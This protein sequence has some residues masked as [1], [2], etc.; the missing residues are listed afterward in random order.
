MVGF[1]RV[2]G[3]DHYVAG[4]VY[5][6]QQ[7]KAFKIAVKT[8]TDAVDLRVTDGKYVEC[9]LEKIIRELNPAMYFTPADASGVICVVL[10]GHAVSAESLQIRIRNV[11]KGAALLPDGSQDMNFGQGT[12]VTQATSLIAG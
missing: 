12:I 5:A 2:N 6:T 10:D 11:L 8:L 7:H 9:T 3:S 4:T 1:A